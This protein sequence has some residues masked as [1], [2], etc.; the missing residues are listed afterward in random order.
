[1]VKYLS[2]Y[3]IM[4]GRNRNYN[5]FETSVVED[6]AV[7]VLCGENDFKVRACALFNLLY[8]LSGLFYLLGPPGYVCSDDW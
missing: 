5:A 3:H 2:Y 1:M 4:Q 6:W 8:Y 7:A